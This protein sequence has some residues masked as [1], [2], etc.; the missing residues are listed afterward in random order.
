MLYVCVCVA[1]EVGL[2]TML[3]VCVAGEVESRTHQV[4]DSWPLRNV[5][6][7]A[8]SLSFVDSVIIV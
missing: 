1:S 6:T 2:M 4:V 5:H 7:L 3:Y 8:V